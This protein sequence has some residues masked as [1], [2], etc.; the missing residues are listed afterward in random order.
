VTAQQIMKYLLLLIGLVLAD[1]HFAEAQ[2]A[3]VYQIGVLSINQAQIAQSTDSTVVKGLRN[4]L[5]EAG[6]VEGKNLILDIPLKRTYEDLRSLAKE[7][8]EQKV[9]AIVAVGGTATRIAK[10]ATREI[11]IVFIYA[12]DPVGSGLLKL[13]A[14]PEPNLTGVT[15]DTDVEF[16]SKRMEIFKELVPTLQRIVLLYNARGENSAHLMRLA[17]IQKLAPTLGL[18]LTEKPI[19]STENMEQALSSVSRDTTDGLFVICSSLFESGFKNIAVKTIQKRLAL[20]G[21]T[22]R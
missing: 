5:K 9:D 18:K 4:G 10:E 21:C 13:L 15:S 12:G 3:K 19:K 6:Y 16:A 22:A 1:V 20:F 8:R 14:R 2:T 17:L 11:P 7:Y